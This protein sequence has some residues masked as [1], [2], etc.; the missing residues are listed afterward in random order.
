MGHRSGCCRMLLAVAAFGLLA[1]AVAEADIG[2]EIGGEHMQRPADGGSAA[3]AG[4]KQEEMMV[5]YGAAAFFLLVAAGIG[6]WAASQGHDPKAAPAGRRVVPDE[7]EA[8]GGG[9]ARRTALARMR[10]RRQ[11]GGED[12]SDDEDVDAGGKKL[13]TKKL[14]KLEQKEEKRVMREAMDEDKA[15]RRE[16]QE[17]QEDDA[18]ERR[19]TE[20]DKE[21]EEEEAEAKRIADLKKKE[22]EEF[23]KWKDMFETGEDGA[24]ADDDLEETQGLLHEFIDYL[25]AKKISPLDE[26]A[27]E[28]K[29]K[30]Q[31]VVNRVEGLEAM[32]R[33]TGLLDDRGKFIYIS[34]EEMQAV[35]KWIRYQGRVSI[36]DLAAESNKL[37]DLQPKEVASRTADVIEGLD[38]EVAEIKST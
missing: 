36:A 23:D 8:V 28:F 25:K 13:G 9:A 29:L 14:A 38:D 27:A 35:A 11:T 15:R 30:S 18:R 10:A 2:D 33:I 24:Q 34:I 16:K 7:A 20:V 21:K 1:S 5:L 6:K 4:P 26:V 12:N 31:E 19:Q 3:K 37:V 17:K 22:E 32:G